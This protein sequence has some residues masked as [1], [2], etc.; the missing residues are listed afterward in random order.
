MRGAREAE[1]QEGIRESAA[2][3]PLLPASWQW[4]KILAISS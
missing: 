1:K 3:F 4:L 2:I